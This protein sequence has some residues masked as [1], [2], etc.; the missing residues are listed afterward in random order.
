[1]ASS[2][3]AFLLDEPTFRIIR[4]LSLGFR[5]GDPEFFQATR[6]LN[7]VGAQANG[8]RRI[9][10]DPDAGFQVPEQIRI[11][12][13]TGTVGQQVVRPASPTHNFQYI[14][15][16]L[17]I[18]QIHPDCLIC[19]HVR[20]EKPVNRHDRPLAAHGR[21]GVGP[22]RG[23]QQEQSPA[24]PRHT[25][26][27]LRKRVRSGNKPALPSRASVEATD[28]GSGTSRFRWQ[29]HQCR[30]PR[31]GNPRSNCRRP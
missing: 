19:I 16:E 7:G 15:G 31:S 11:R 13:K 5:S 26:A 4:L 27:P 25:D 21:M 22:R 18:F 30:P 17:A 2:C 24:I 1:M 6:Q 9:S 23:G 12:F 28:A 29:A 20:I 14:R 8:A 3:L 10:Q